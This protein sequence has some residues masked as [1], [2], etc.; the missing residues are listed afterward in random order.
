MQIA[1]INLAKLSIDLPTC[2]VTYSIKHWA[3]FMHLF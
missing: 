3:F 1:N 2:P